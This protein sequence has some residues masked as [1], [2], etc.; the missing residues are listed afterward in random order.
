M[1][2]EPTAPR[3][4]S[5]GLALAIVLVI[6]QALDAH[7]A[8]RWVRAQFL[9]GAWWQLLSAQLV[10]LGWLHA[11]LNGLALVLLLYALT[12]WLTA[13]LLGLAG[14][15]GM[16]GVAAVLLMDAQC[17]TYAGASGALHGLWAGAAWALW[18][19]QGA[20]NTVRLG[21]LMLVALLVKL[22]A[23]RLADGA[24]L[25]LLPGMPVY[26]PAHEAGVAGGWLVVGLAVRWQRLRAAQG[27]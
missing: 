9:A 16:L 26:L 12:P 3:R 11:L 21:A 24:T 27:H 20:P 10:H 4:W 8:L 2:F 22:V 1:S 5:V 6:A 13:R 18:R 25:G 23:Q 15:G 14:L 7:A 17:A 19:G